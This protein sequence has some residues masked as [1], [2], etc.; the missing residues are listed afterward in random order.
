MISN[1]LFYFKMSSHTTA[2]DLS[3]TVFGKTW[4][5]PITNASGCLCT[6]STEIWNI[7]N[8]PYTGAVVS[9]SCTIAHRKGNPKP[10]YQCVSEN[11]DSLLTIN[12]MGIPNLG[13]DKYIDISKNCATEFPDKSFVLSL[14]GLKLEEKKQ[15]FRTL[16]DVGDNSGISF[17]EFN[18]SCPNLIGKPQL[19]LDFED[20]D[21]TLQTITEIY[22][23]PFGLKLPP[24]H[25]F[26][27]FE[28]AADIIGRYPVSSIT[29]CNSV[30]N[31]LVIDVDTESTVIKPKGGFGG[32]GGKFMLPI[33]LAN[34]RK[35]YELLDDKVDIIGCGGVTS[36]AD[37][38]SY[39]LCGAKAVQVGSY[40]RE[41]GMPVFEKI[42]NELSNIMTT[43]NYNCISD[44]RGKLRQL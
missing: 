44:Y 13:L 20:F 38:F 36:G 23:K 12:S 33:G 1:D 42:T 27:Y 29:C 25:D 26:A 2:M 15:M 17:V 35:F 19:G 18:V 41:N 37:V 5:Y 14:S 10:R 34:V 21:Q 39:I 8:S 11:Q 31:G 7:M 3:T 32:I 30:G 9:K 22:D 16:Q 28:K 6:S 43:K 4:K 40:F 24:Y